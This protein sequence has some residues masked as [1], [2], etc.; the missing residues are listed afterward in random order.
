M[1]EPRHTRANYRPRR[2]VKATHSEIRV[3]GRWY[4]KCNRVSKV[5]WPGYLTR[6]LNA[7]ALILF[8]AIVSIPQEMSSLSLIEWSD[9]LDL[10]SGNSVAVIVDLPAAT[11]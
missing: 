6:S 8:L 9:V 3:V 11:E 10:L 7:V 4:V 5:T 2:V 1:Y